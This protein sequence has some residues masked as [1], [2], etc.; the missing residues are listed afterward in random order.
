[1]SLWW[2]LV[3]V[4]IINYCL[5][6]GS[7][8]LS[9]RA[10]RIRQELAYGGDAAAAKRIILP[11]FRP[12]FRGLIAFYGILALALSLTFVDTDIEGGYFHI[13]QYFNFCSISVFVI[14]PV[15]LLQSSV[16]VGAFWKSFYIVFPWWCLCS[17][18]WGL[19]YINGDYQLIFSLLFV[20]TAS[21]PPVILSVLMLTKSIKSRV[22]LGSV[23][24][25]NSIE[26]LLL[27]ALLYGVFYVA[28]L[29]TNSS[30]T[31]FKLTAVLTAV[32]FVCNQIFPF[33]LYRTLLADTKFWRGLGRHNKMGINVHDDLRESGVAV[34]RPTMD[35]SVI[36]STFQ[37]MMAGIGNISVDFAYLQLERIIGH[38]ATSEVYCGRYKKKLVAIKLSNPPEVTE[39]AIDVFVAE[40]RIA[41]SLSHPN[42]VQFVGICVRPPQIAM[43]FEFC[44]GGNLKSN[45]QK[46]ADKWTPAK[47]INACLDACRAMEAFHHQGLIHRDLKAENFFVGRKQI[48]KL[49]DFGESTHTRT[50]ESTA[51]RRMT[52]LGTVAFM[53]PELIAAK[54]HYTEAIDI[55]ALAIT[56]W[57]IWTGR[58]PYE[59]ISQF[60]IY[61]KVAQGYRPGLPDN[62][63]PGFNELLQAAWQEDPA[64]RPDASDLLAQVE[65]VYRAFTGQAVP[66]V[67]VEER[68]SLFR[69]NS[70]QVSLDSSA[71]NA[72]KR[73]SKDTLTTADSSTVVLES[74]L[75]K[76]DPSAFAGEITTSAEVNPLHAR[77]ASALLG[78][79]AR[80]EVSTSTAAS[81]RPTSGLSSV[82]SAH[83][84]IELATVTRSATAL[85]SASAPA[86]T[87]AGDSIDRDAPAGVNSSL[88]NPDITQ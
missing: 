70:K 80:R 16:S 81:S 83:S 49:G 17:I 65:E 77:V 42:I 87:L 1:M 51:S 2:T 63:P 30:D 55:Y 73:A 18:F 54:R 56:L 67:E 39:E 27:Y 19:D 84:D 25:R 7:L 64:L 52:I 15:L 60:D 3:A 9:I 82:G 78:S 48:V 20:L 6:T 66:V 76:G 86:S 26:F 5:T 61:T 46:N 34:F 50:V 14:T 38:G 11:C 33:A 45:L 85:A 53:A 31:R 32:S 58:D 75:V 12:L 57:E 10:A 79:P 29:A 21:V 24:N 8:L 40:A 41:A 28:A 37:D 47:R 69:T 23:S 59:D 72:A 36:T 4:C 22:Q 68:P 88:N 62:A 44:E 35:M 13:L 43:V 71:G 74:G